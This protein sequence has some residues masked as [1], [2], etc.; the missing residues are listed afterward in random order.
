MWG[1]DNRRR[2]TELLRSSC[3]DRSPPG[4]GSVQDDTSVCCLLCTLKAGERRV[5]GGKVG[6]WVRGRER[7]ERERE[8]EREKRLHSPFALHNQ[9]KHQAM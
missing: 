5:V 1:E 8:R 4:Q 2:E 7:G 9:Q 6:V 3:V